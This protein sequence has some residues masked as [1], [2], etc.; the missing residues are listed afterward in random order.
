MVPEQKLDVRQEDYKDTGVEVFGSIPNKEKIESVPSTLK[1]IANLF[2][3]NKRADNISKE[4]EK[5]INDKKDAFEK[6]ENKPKVL[7]LGAEK[8]KI[9]V[10]NMIQTQIIEAAGGINASTDPDDKDA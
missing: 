4:F 10:N 3:E 7:F 6:A 1:M 5:V 8:Y 9:A 2:G